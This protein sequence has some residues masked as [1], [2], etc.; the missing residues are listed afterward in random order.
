MAV[1]P[2]PEASARKILSI[3]TKGGSQ[4]GEGALISQLNF[5]FINA[6]GAAA[7]FTAGI[8]FA[9]EQGWIEQGQNNFV[10]LTEAG[11]SEA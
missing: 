2:T 4:A 11:F 10:L 8:M 9:G 3:L 6:G 1:V 7:D 5:N